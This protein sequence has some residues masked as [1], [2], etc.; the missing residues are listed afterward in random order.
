MIPCYTLLEVNVGTEKI[1]ARPVRWVI[2]DV[3]GFGHDKDG[4]DVVPSGYHATC[5]KCGNL[6]D[7]AAEQIYID[8]HLVEYVA[9]D[10][11]NAGADKI[12]DID[13]SKPIEDSEIIDPIKDGVFDIEVD[14]EVLET[15]EDLGLRSITKT[16]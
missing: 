13:L 9:C 8:E 11:C 14:L 6:I 7:F 4:N 2:E 1:L 12:G 10:N 3:D 15:L 5:P 16:F